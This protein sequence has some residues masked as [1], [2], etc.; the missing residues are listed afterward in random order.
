MAENEQKNVNAK[1]PTRITPYLSR[2]IRQSEPI[3]KQF[4]PN[5]REL[6]LD[7]VDSPWNLEN[8]YGINGLGEISNNKAVIIPTIT[9]SAY[10]RYCIRKDRK[11]KERKDMTLEDIL[12]MSKILKDHTSL[13]EILITGGDPF[14]KPDMLLTILEE[15][16][17]IP[18]INSIRI[19]T[20]LTTVDPDRLN[21][22]LLKQV[23]NYNKF[24]KPIEISIQY[25][26]PDEL[27]EKSILALERISSCNIKTYNQ[28]VLLRG[29]NDDADVLYQLYN[30]LIEMGV[31]LLYLYHCAP[32]QGTSHLRTSVQKGIEIKKEFTRMG[33]SGRAIPKYVLVTNVGKLEPFVDCDLIKK[34][35]G[36]LHIKTCYDAKKDEM[37][38]MTY[39]YVDKSG[40]IVVK[41]LDGN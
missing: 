28:S 25:N 11:S 7:G 17:K 39:H 21:L 5:I 33:L 1:F 14:T 34:E 18:N 13:R 12:D 22:G 20:R 19:G 37:L 10:C 29:V 23:A 4:M 32:I 27:T 8:K 26:H 15:L 35:D 24:G 40:F 30:S 9:C 16:R 6:D 3:R 2:L 41:Y 38:P 31:E 36:F